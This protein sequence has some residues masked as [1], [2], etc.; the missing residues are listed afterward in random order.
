MNLKVTKIIC[1]SILYNAE[2]L[3]KTMIKIAQSLCGMVFIVRIYKLNQEL[4]GYA[5]A[6]KQRYRR[7]V[8]CLE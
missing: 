6:R 1:Y 4:M 5:F 7:H 3:C 2:L 8:L